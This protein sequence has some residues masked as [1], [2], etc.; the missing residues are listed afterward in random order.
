MNRFRAWP[1]LLTA[2]T[3]LLTSPALAQSG[4]IADGTWTLRELRDAS[5]T[6][7]F[8]GLDAPTLRLLGTGISTDEGTQV[9]GST[10]CNTF[11]T[12]AIFTAQTLKLRPLITTRRACPAPQLALEQRYLQVLQGARV[13]VRQG[14]T[15]TLTTGRAQAI[16]VYGSEAS[17]QLVTTWRLVG[18]QG[19]PP[20]TLS[21][22]ADGRVSGFSGCNTFMGRY[23]VDDLALSVGPL[24]TTRR[25]CAT[26]AQQAQEM[27]VLGQLEQVTRLELSGPHLTL[28]T[29]DG[30]RIQW[31]RPVN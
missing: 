9:S 22:T 21:F 17:R 15:L 31:A 16:F 24:V 20:V 13:Y 29:R 8:G 4:Q 6:Q 11:K 14:T 5:G 10:G 1:V 23:T 19:E 2:L 7:S 27:R 18:G 26:S 30:Q 25:A 3:S 28:I 12:T